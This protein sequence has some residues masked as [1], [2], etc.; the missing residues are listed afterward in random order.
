MWGSLS[1]VMLVDRSLGR[2]L[3]EFADQGRSCPAVRVEVRRSSRPGWLVT[4][5]YS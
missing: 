3:G 4:V 5:Q 1:P 2:R